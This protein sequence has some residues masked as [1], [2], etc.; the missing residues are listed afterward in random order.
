[1]HD[2]EMERDHQRFFAASVKAGGT[3]AI[4]AL[5]LVGLMG[6]ALV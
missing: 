2:L 3:I 6:L 1:M 4:L 5:V